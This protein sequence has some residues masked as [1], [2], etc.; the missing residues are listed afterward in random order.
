MAKA[1]VKRTVDTELSEVAGQFV[2]GS[3]RV[4]VAVPGTK[5]TIA[6]Y[7]LAALDCEECPQSGDAWS[8]E[9]PRLCV[10]SRSP[11]LV[12][13]GRDGRRNVVID[14]KYILEPSERGFPLRGGASLCQIKSHKK[15]LL[16][17]AGGVEVDSRG[18]PLYA[19]ISY[20]YN[21]AIY[22]AEINPFAAEGYETRQTVEYTNDPQSIKAEWI[23]S[24]NADEWNHDRPYS[25]LVARIDHEILNELT[26]PNRY[27]FTWSFSRTAKPNGWRYYIAHRDSNGNIPG[28]FDIESHECAWHV[29]VE[30]SDKFPWRESELMPV[31]RG[32]RV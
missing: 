22:K 20:G 4:F 3:R 29:P 19:A 6:D 17:S 9:F 1:I 8:D 24:V 14:L 27:L 10:R 11:R 28:D 5:D 12:G 26:S 13:V 18:R 7:L 25:W 30:F 15:L 32:G 23:N 31:K 16:N 2:S 21:D